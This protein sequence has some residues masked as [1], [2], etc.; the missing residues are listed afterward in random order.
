MNNPFDFLMLTAV[1]TVEV[2]KTL[3]ISGTAMIVCGVLLIAAGLIVRGRS[4]RAVPI[5]PDEEDITELNEASG[6]SVY[7]ESVIGDRE[8]QQDYF[9]FAQGAENEERVRAGRLAVVCD[10]MGG[11]KGG[12][13]ASRCCAE[14]IFNGFYQ[15]GW[16]ENVRQ[17]LQQLVTAAD[18][19]VSG[20]S[21]ADG[22]PLHC[23]TTAIAVVIRDKKAYWVSTGDSR[24]YY[25]HNGRLQQLTR[26]HNFRMT[27]QERCAAGQITQE[28][29]ENNRQKEAL[30]SYVGK[31]G[32]LIVDT[33]EFDFP[34]GRGDILLLCSD[35]L[36]KSI[37]DS[38]IQRLMMR[39]AD[40]VSRLPGIL[41]RAAMAGGRPG[42][43]DNTTVLAIG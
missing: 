19:E 32:N 15:I 9:L 12:E 33:G 21:S 34:Q 2:Y 8:Y 11:I 30:I 24:I 14:T 20:I 25:F 36:Y 7:V 6:V 13:L 28:Q 3:C 27:L 43:H 10:G 26:D 5:Q 40:N 22:K 29:V 1:M 42:K 31:G 41:V 23:G 37:P 17:I 16:T 4:R 38:E 35:G 39:N 18:K